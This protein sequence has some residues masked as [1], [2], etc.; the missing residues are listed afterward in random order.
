[1]CAVA[2][3][4][5]RSAS[6]SGRLCHGDGG[7]EGVPTAGWRYCCLSSLRNPTHRYG[8]GEVASPCG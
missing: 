2:S 8:V 5:W 1:M 6:Q 7:H 4:L 3:P